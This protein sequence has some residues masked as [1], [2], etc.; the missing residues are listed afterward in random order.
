MEDINHNK[1][2]V[3]YK[4]EA[5]EPST[6]IDAP[7]EKIDFYAKY[8]AME[9]TK[10]GNLESCMMHKEVYCRIQHIH[11]AQGPEIIA[12]WLHEINAQLGFGHKA[13]RIFVQEQGLNSPY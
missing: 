4:P 3:D 8:A 1:V 13:A 6:E 10:D 5:L 2:V 7:Q 9:L 11:P 12:L